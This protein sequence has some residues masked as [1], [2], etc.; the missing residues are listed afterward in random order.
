MKIRS[1]N[2][3]DQK[4]IRLLW[5]D[6]FGDPYEYID[7]YLSK[8][9]KPEFCAILE[10]NGDVIGMI[11]LLKCT[12]YP[13]QKAFYWYA[14]GIRS[15]RRKEGLFRKLAQYVKE[16][17]NR[18]GYKNLCVPAP[19]LEKYYQSLGFSFAYTATD[20]IFINDCSSFSCDRV[21]IQEASA[22]DFLNE[23]FQIGDTLWDKDAVEY[24]MKENVYCNG[25]LLKI[26]IQDQ[27]YHCFAIRKE[28]SF[29]IEYHNIPNEVFLKIK[30]SLFEKL[31]CKKLI[32]RTCGNQK[33]V[34]LSDSDLVKSTSR[35]TMTLA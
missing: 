4:S 33:T 3:F 17:T 29:L 24:A 12:V 28:N 21:S 2:L 32:F 13:N 6:C 8:R 7:F 23:T 26:T 9:F 10:D 18:L 16:Q 31:S 5:Q 27:S 20:E 22:E 14:A 35:I 25:F 19:G 34:G 11:H 1:A 15:D 30:N